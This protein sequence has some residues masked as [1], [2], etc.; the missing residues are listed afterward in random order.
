MDRRATLATL[1]GRKSG[2]ST[3]N[4]G[5]EPYE[6]PWE[7]EQA[8][9]LLRRSMFGPTN[10]QIKQAVNDGLDAIIE[11]LFQELPL[12][13]PPLNPRFEEDPNVAI[14][15][16]WVEAPYIQGVNLAGYRFNSLA[17]WTFIKSATGPI[18]QEEIGMKL[19]EEFKVSIYFGELKIEETKSG[20]IN[21]VW[22]IEKEF[23]KDL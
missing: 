2:T 23:K 5:L 15:E 13:D 6:G 14:G 9:H 11:S 12:P 10:T 19:L 16:T 20:G 7:Y 3:I 4:S 1:L 21:Y 22:K 18:N 17:A 8:A